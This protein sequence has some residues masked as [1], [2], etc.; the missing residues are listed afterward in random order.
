MIRGVSHLTL[1]KNVIFKIF[2][3]NKMKQLVVWADNKTWNPTKPRYLIVTKYVD[4]R[5]ASEVPLSSSQMKQLRH[6]ARG[7]ILNA[8]EVDVYVY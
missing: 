5:P 2:A 4:C 6:L 8:Y 3:L 1:A 7:L